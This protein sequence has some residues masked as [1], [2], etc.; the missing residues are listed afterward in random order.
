VNGSNRNPTAARDVVV[1]P[2]GEEA[3]SYA[4]GLRALLED[5][6]H[7]L[8]GGGVAMAAYCG[9]RRFTKDLDV[10]VLPED[11]PRALGAFSRAG[12]RTEIPFPHWLAK[13]YGDEHE[14]IDVIYNSGNGVAPVDAEW[15]VHAPAARV[16]GVDV[17]LCPPE[18]TIWSKAFVMERERFDG[19]DVAHLLLTCGPSID[20]PRL[21]RRFG[22]HWRVLLSHLVLFGYVYP[23]EAGCVPQ[24]VIGPLLERLAGEAHPPVDPEGRTCRGTLLSREQYLPDLARGWR[25]ARLPPTGSMS[26]EAVHRWTEAIRAR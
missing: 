24:G 10:F 12:F 19:A 18:E 8:V 15:F 11:V 26:A 22:E 9:I 2:T 5:G 14:F 17:A 20:W 3:P 25:D 4:R 6:V 16:L 23:D 13:A 7:F 21:V 1:E